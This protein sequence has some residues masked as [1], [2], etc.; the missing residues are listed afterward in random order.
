MKI[1]IESPETARQSRLVAD[2]AWRG[3]SQETTQA[4]LESRELDETAFIQQGAAS[5][6]LV[7]SWGEE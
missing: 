6:D 4:I 3:Y 7:V 2:Y 1:Y 5:A